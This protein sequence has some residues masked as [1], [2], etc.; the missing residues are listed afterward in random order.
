MWLFIVEVRFEGEDHDPRLA[1]SETLFVGRPQMAGICDLFRINGAV[2]NHV[3]WDT[4]QVT[5]YCPE[6]VAGTIL[7]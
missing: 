6:D 4:S 1:A 7:G 3:V 2:P 5:R